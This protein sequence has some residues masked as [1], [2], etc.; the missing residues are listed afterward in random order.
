M[1]KLA[2][3]ALNCPKLSK[4]ITRLYCIVLLLALKIFEIPA[5]SKTGSPFDA[6]QSFFLKKNFILFYNYGGNEAK[7]SKLRQK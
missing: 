6:R 3:L 7:S 4:V 2:K 1:R 5:N